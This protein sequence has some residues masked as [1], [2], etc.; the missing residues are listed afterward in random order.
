MEKYAW[1]RR[2]AQVSTI[3]TFKKRYAFDMAFSESHLE[4]VTE[5]RQAAAL[6]H[7]LRLRI[8]HEA[9]QPASASELGARLGVP[10]QRA[11]HH[12]RRLAGAGL[13]RPAGRRKKGN[14][15][16]NR[17][18]ASAL[19]YLISPEILG[20]ARAD[21][22][23]M[24]ESRTTSYLLALLAHVEIDLLRLLRRGSSDGDREG[25]RTISLKTQFMVASGERRAELERGLREAIAQVIGSAGG[26]GP[27]D[28]SPSGQVYRMVVACYPYA[29]EVPGRR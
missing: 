19:G 23:Q 16:E 5:P 26:P 12:V 17:Y 7:P 21:W 1:A 9:R 28:P 11:N 25:D 14:L 24:G 22:R 8:L 27:D 2:L 18:V 3:S 15:Y 13:L 20:D 6:L 10:R 29:A 4:V